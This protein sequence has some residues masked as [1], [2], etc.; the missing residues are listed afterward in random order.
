MITRIRRTLVRSW[1]WYFTVFSLISLL[2][3]I[4]DYNLNNRTIVFVKRRITSSLKDVPLE[5][6][7]FPSS[8]AKNTGIKIITKQSTVEKE[9]NFDP[10]KSF[11]R[12]VTSTSKKEKSD[13]IKI[14][15]IETEKEFIKRMEKRMETRKDTLEKACHLLGVI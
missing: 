10:K 11:T 4:T 2:F 6:K 5:T 7:T 14:S 13:N 3:I 12:T 9:V 1:R 8:K 15:K